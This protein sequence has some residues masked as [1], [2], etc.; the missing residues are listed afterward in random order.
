[1]RGALNAFFQEL[2]VK[3]RRVI[4]FYSKLVHLGSGRGTLRLMHKL[5]LTQSFASSGILLSRGS[6]GR[7]I[8]ELS[9]ILLIKIVGNAM[10]REEFVVLA[11][12][13]K[14]RQLRVRFII[15]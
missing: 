8:V 12:N 14:I 2:L 6:K 10:I 11:K 1:M 13:M 15:K 9:E 5:G 7:F 4:F 3:I